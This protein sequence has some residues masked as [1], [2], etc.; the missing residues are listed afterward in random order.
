MTKNRGILKSF[1]NFCIPWGIH[2]KKKQ[3]QGF[4]VQINKQGSKIHFDA[5]IVKSAD[6]V[7]GF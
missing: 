6:K 1:S 3:T 4:E 2:K 7:D 5:K